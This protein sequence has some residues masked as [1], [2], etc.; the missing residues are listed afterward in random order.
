M[1]TR[2]C[3]VCKEDLPLSEFS[4]D[5]RRKSGVAGRCKACKKAQDWRRNGEGMPERDWDVP[6]LRVLS[7]GAGVQSSTLFL[8]SCLGEVPK[9]DAAIF[10]DVGWEHPRVYDWLENVLRPAGERAG[11]PI[12]T[13]SVGNIQE[14][15]NLVPER[16][17]EPGQMRGFVVVPA[18]TKNK[19]GEGVGMLRRQCTKEYKIVPIQT[20]LFRLSGRGRKKVEQWFGISI[21]EIQRMQRASERQL[22]VKFAYPLID[23][24]MSRDDC[25]RWLV[26]HGF[27]MAPRSSCMGCPYHADDEWSL[28]KNDP[29]PANFE[30]VVK[31]ERRM[32]DSIPNA[33]L[34]RSCVPIDQVEFGNDIGGEECEGYCWT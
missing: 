19:D 5:R 8:M 32:Q 30:T 1:K 10:A 17:G 34:H 3:S 25:Q 2:V 18:F 7:L 13:V 21:D 22:Y 31:F 4:K 23:A 27:E 29:D 26:D 33:F 6:D 15:Q 20:E 9:L 11:I 28:L 12:T 24:G 16:F 14:R